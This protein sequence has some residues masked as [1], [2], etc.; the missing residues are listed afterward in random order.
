MPQ[1]NASVRAE[2]INRRIASLLAQNENPGKVDIN[3]DNPRKIATLRIRNPILM[4]VTQQD[5]EDFGL[6]AEY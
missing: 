3:P 1:I 2:I 5:A 6:T 4:T